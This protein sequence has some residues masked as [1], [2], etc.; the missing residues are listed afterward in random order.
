MKLLGFD[1]LY[2]LTY[3]DIVVKK[4]S[5]IFNMILYLSLI[6]SEIL[7]SFLNFVSLLVEYRIFKNVIYNIVLFIIFII[8]NYYIY[9]IKRRRIRI[10]KKYVFHKTIYIDIIFV[11]SGI[12]FIY[13]I[14]INNK[15]FGI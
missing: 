8:L 10:Q 9:E 11:I 14:Y 7:S 13:S 4:K 5:Q 15:F 12:L 3:E 2:M 1:Y 6:Y